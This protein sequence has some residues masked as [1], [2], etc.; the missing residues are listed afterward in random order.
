MPTDPND[1]FSFDSDADG[2]FDKTVKFDYYYIWDDEKHPTESTLAILSNGS[3]VYK[4]INLKGLSDKY[5]IISD[6]VF[7][8]GFVP[9]VKDLL[10]KM[11]NLYSN[12]SS[13]FGMLSLFGLDLDPLIDQIKFII[14]KNTKEDP[15]DSSNKI[16]EF[17]DV[18]L[19]KH[20]KNLNNGSIH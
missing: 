19:L 4:E 11:L 14:S 18:D 9:Y 2:T 20:F 3:H 13:L 12:S 17:S 5:P 6:A 8:T 1:A 16:V 15:N 10:I 7:E